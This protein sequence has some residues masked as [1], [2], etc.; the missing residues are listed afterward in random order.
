VSNLFR[1]S[2]IVGAFLLAACS[3][4]EPEAA[5]PVA[6]A[7]PTVNLEDEQQKF[8]YAIGISAFK[9]IENGL[10]GIEGTEVELD[11]EMILKGFTDSLR[12]DSELDDQGLRAAI[13][14]FQTRVT[15]V[16]QAKTEAEAEV[17]SKEGQA[18]LEENKSSAGVVALASGLQYLVLESGEGQSPSSAST[19]VKVHYQGTLIDG[20]QFDSS[21]D[22][23]EPASFALNQ[24]IRGW[25]EGVQ[26]M[27]E[28][29]KWRFFI[30]A[31]LA[32]GQ[33]STATIPAGSTLIFEVELLEVVD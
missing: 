32:Y 5:V 13:T 31:D 16:Q 20:T 3:Q 10:Q 11:K 30:P 28:G 8:S 18:Y 9:N 4:P 26:L 17:H 29:A 25:T 7:A 27:K 33:R 24:V 1:L 22:R 12:G 6:S 15:E 23:G 2:I 19:T 14:Q 21:Y